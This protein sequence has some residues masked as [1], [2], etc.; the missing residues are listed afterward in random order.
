[1]TSPRMSCCQNTKLILENFTHQNLQ[2]SNA[3]TFNVTTFYIYFCLQ[4]KSA[5][6]R[7]KVGIFK[8]TNTSNSVI[9]YNAYRLVTFITGDA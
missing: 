9:S 7:F 1:M 6:F 3:I 4:G 5:S 8:G 2:K